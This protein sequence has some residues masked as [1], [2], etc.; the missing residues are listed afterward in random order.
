MGVTTNLDFAVDAMNKIGIPAHFVEKL[1]TKQPLVLFLL[2]P[3]SP[4]LYPFYS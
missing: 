1:N 2:F 4:K 3:L